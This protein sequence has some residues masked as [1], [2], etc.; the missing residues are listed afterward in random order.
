[1]KKNT[2]FSIIELLVAIG[3]MGIITTISIPTFKLW[4]Q[5]SDYTDTISKIIE[6]NNTARV[7]AQA[8]KICKADNNSTGTWAIKFSQD[9]VEIGCGEI[10]SDSN[11][12]FEAKSSETVELD[13]EL[14]AYDPALDGTEIISTNSALIIGWSSANETLHG[15]TFY[16]YNTAAVAGFKK[17]A[18]LRFESQYNFLPVPNETKS[19]CLSRIA[20]YPHLSKT[21]FDD[22]NALYQTLCN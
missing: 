18:D 19:I 10:D 20:G 6:L 12:D 16:K 5:R 8:E 22:S 14:I 17:I 21:V 11:F 13:N 3:I 7:A 4:G 2:G 9:K 15:A 1:M